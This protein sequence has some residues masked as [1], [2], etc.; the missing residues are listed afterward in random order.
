MSYKNVIIILEE[1]EKK[2]QNA[3]LLLFNR[4][5][6]YLLVR[7]VGKSRQGRSRA[8]WNLD[9]ALGQVV[10]LRLLQPLLPTQ[11]VLGEV[12]THGRCSRRSGDHVLRVFGHESVKQLPMK[13]GPRYVLSASPERL[14]VEIVWAPRQAYITRSISRLIQEQLTAKL[15]WNF[16]FGLVQ[17]C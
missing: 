6:F 5:N 16:N 15:E 14:V 11:E 8:S 4:R 7:W 12:G 10:E 13:V 17:K 3:C 2:K 9:V 1:E